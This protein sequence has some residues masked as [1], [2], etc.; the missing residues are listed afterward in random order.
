MEHLEEEK[1][2]DDHLWQYL[3][4][5]AASKNLRIDIEHY[6]QPS[7]ETSFQSLLEDWSQHNN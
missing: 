6:M 7:F 5:I 4:K 3:W 2:K 1:G